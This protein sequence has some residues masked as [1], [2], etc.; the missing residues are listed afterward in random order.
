[1]HLSPDQVVYW[2]QGIVKLN[3][4]IVTTWALMLLL[5]IGSWLVTRKL[6]TG[7]QISRWQNLLEI[8]VSAL[9]QQ[10]QEVG[11]EE[12]DKYLAFLGTLFL[13]IALSNL[14]TLLPVYEPPT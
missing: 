9:K 8:I 5:I 2:Q 3:S 4:T 12:P 11:L 14:G 1:M 7:M 13:F 6:S 10:I